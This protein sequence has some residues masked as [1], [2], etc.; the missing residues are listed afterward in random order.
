MKQMNYEKKKCRFER[1]RKKDGIFV[2]CFLLSP[3]LFV[4]CLSRVSFFVFRS[5]PFFAYRPPSVFSF[6][7]NSVPQLEKNNYLQK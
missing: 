7:D 1:G 2:L 5:P 3:A 4:L 6:F